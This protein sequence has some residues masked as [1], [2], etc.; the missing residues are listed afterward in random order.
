MILQIIDLVV[1]EYRN[2][3]FKCITALGVKL[4]VLFR[5]HNRLGKVVTTKC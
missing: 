2:T 4:G 5:G 3:N 1:F